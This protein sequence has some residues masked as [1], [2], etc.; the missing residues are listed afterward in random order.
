MFSFPLSLFHPH[1]ISQELALYTLSILSAHMN[2]RPVE[3][4]VP[5][6]RS[7][8]HSSITR[9]AT[10]FLLPLFFHFQSHL[11]LAAPLP[12]RQL[13]PNFNRLMERVFKML[14][15]CT[16]FTDIL[17]KPGGGS[18]NDTPGPFTVV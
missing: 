13:N 3:L 5:H 12:L 1:T 16:S 8:N 10:F 14:T 11:L 7:S 4:L 2:V 9:Q 17:Q 15:W 6:S 18:R